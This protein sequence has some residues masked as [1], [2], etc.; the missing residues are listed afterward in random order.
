VFLKIPNGGMYILYQW[1]FEF[2]LTFGFFH[3]NL[4]SRV[5]S[6]VGSHLIGDLPKRQE[7]SVI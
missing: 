3:L 6:S 5:V 7:Q 2:D 4:C 1:S